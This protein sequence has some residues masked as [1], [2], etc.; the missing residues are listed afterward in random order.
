M[1]P[2]FTEVDIQTWRK[3]HLSYH[4]KSN[5]FTLDSEMYAT[6][7]FWEDLVKDSRA[8]YPDFHPKTNILKHMRT[9]FLTLLKNLTE[10]REAGVPKTSGAPNCMTSWGR[11]RMVWL[12]KP[13]H[14]WS[15]IMCGYWLCSTLMAIG[16]SQ[17]SL[18]RA[19]ACSK[20]STTQNLALMKSAYSLQR[21]S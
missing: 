9:E 16:D 3:V 20:G 17:R 21:K 11:S 12:L 18:F 1:H 2:P 19:W 8:S 4:G 5:A 7:S 14:A 10:A 13:N 15:I 6:E